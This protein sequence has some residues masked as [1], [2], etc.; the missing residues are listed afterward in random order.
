MP[1]SCLKMCKRLYGSYCNASLVVPFGITYFTTLEAMPPL[2]HAPFVPH[3]H[4]AY[5]HQPLHTENGK[6]NQPPISHPRTHPIRID[7]HSILRPALVSALLSTLATN[8]KHGHLLP[9]GKSEQRTSWGR[10]SG[11]QILVQRT[12]YSPKARHPYSRYMATITGLS[13]LL[14]GHSRNNP[15]IHLSTN[16]AHSL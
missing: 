7:L 15:P 16:P 2:R 13:M 6:T 14:K 9:L 12:P 5:T 10:S 1:D 4:C 11:I 3:M 8:S